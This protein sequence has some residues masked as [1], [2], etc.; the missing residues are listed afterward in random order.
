[1]DARS[2]IPPLR[3]QP[4]WAGSG[5]LGRRAPPY[6]GGARVVSTAPSTNTGASITSAFKAYLCRLQEGDRRDS[7]PRPSE[8]QSA[9]ACFRVLPSVEQSAYLSQFL[10]WWLPTVSACSSLSGVRNGVK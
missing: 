1:M 2:R 9:D 4:Q 6:R 5:L 3:S 10:C 8:P 7:N